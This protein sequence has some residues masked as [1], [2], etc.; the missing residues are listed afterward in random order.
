MAY[1]WELVCKGLKAGPVTVTL[2]REKRSLDQNAK[3]WAM[4][5]DVS[6]QVVWHG[7]KLTNDTWKNIFTAALFK[8]DTVPGIDGGFVVLGKPTSKMRKR[9]FAEL[10]EL[11]YAFGAER[12]VKWSEKS[13][14]II[15]EYKKWLDEDRAKEG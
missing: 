3:L 9:T 6:K 10:I 12:G 8:Q 7:Q 15:A 4:L 13:D 5:A 11:I 14:D 2:G 1:A